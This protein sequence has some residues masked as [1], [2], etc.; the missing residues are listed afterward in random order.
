[1]NR[2][3]MLGS[4]FLAA[5]AA[6][7][8]ACAGTP[9]PP[10]SAPSTAPTSNASTPGT[11][12][13]AASAPAAA[14][15]AA[16]APPGGSGNAMPSGSAAPK[17]P[18]DASLVAAAT[19][20]KPE[21]A[22]NVV[23]VSFPRTDVR[24]DV[25]GIK[26][27]PFMGLT[28]WAGFVAGEKPGIEA[29]V[30]GDL[31]LFEDEVNRAMS[32]AL[33]N[34]LEVTALHNHFFFDKPHVFFMHIGGEGTVEQLG[35]GVKSTLEAV[36]AVRQKAPKPAAEF[37]PPPPATSKIDAAQLDAIFGAKGAAKDG[38][39]KGVFGRKTQAECGCTIGAAMGVNTWAAFAGT[40]D[41]AVVDGDFAIAE[42]ELQPVL[43]SLRGNGINIVSIHSHM[44]GE[45]PRILFLHYWGRG[46]AADLASA[47][48]HALDLTQWDGRTQ[49]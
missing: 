24:I 17:P 2:N 29:M 35:K 43:K 9:P 13:V 37:G 5:V 44:S 46:R 11:S 18:L 16:S 14:P 6:L 25:D 4:I 1:M 47:V 41:N 15:V 27:P 48:K 10:A 49:A 28:S 39:Y 21:V 26:M 7:G 20:A 22:G 3:R 45:S 31:V 42:S 8:T 32:A 38:M 36:H 12:E 19:G 40:D 34:G 33:D 23:K 30:M